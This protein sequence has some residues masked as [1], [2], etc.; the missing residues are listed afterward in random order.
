MT[1]VK[2][3]NII[4]FDPSAGLFE[5]SALG[6]YVGTHSCTSVESMAAASHLFE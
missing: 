4:N 2:Q 3:K 1:Q 5:S 6:F